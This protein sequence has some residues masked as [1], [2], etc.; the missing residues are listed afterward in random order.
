[1]NHIDDIERVVD[2]DQLY[3]MRGSFDNHKFDGFCLTID[4]FY[5]NAEDLYQHLIN[6]QYPLWKYNSESNTRNGIDYFDCRVVDKVGH[7]TSLYENDQQ[8]LIDLCIRYFWKSNY[9]WPRLYE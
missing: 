4:D 3:R 1:M 8:S 9:A 5:E 7:P 2:L 6:R